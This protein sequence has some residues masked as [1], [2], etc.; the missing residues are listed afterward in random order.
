MNAQPV[1]LP[2]ATTEA[3]DQKSCELLAFFRVR[4]GCQAGVCTAVALEVPAVA[5]LAV[6]VAA[7]A[8][9]MRLR[10]I[11]GRSFFMLFRTPPGRL[12]LP[13]CH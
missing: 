2:V 4:T 1:V 10:E 12:Q 7:S 3:K 9:P 8:T 13:G 11:F 5:V 6:P